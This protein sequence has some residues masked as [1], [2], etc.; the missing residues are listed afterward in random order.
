[1]LACLHELG[2]RRLHIGVQSLEDPVRR[3]IGRRQSA[4]SVLSKTAEVI[5]MGWVVSVDLLCGLPDQSL[6]GFL[7]G[8]RVLCE[9]GVH[10]FSLYEL[11]IYPQNRKW[12]ERFGLLDREHLGNY[13]MFQAGA[14]YLKALGYIKNLFNHWADERDENLYFTFPSRSEDLLALGTIADGVFGDYHYRHPTYNRYRQR[15]SGVFPALEGGTRRNALENRLHPLTT[16]ILAGSIPPTLAPA[17]ELRLPGSG[18]TLLERWLDLDLLEEG[19][20]DGHLCLTANG[21]W[22]AGNMISQLA[23]LYDSPF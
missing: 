18:G 11:L 2:F 23:A 10:G 6:E 5:E 7:E 20:Q 14:S 4:A 1:M 16:A 19:A 13:W 12:A 9:I 8:I 3:H 17:F 22:F 15:V 21:S